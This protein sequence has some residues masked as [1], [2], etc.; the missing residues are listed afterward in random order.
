MPWRPL[1]LPQEEVSFCTMSSTEPQFDPAGN[2]KRTSVKR[3]NAESDILKYSVLLCV[4][5]YVITVFVHF[6]RY[7]EET[8]DDELMLEKL[9]ECKGVKVSECPFIEKDLSLLYPKI[10][11]GAEVHPK[12]Q[13]L[14]VKGRAEGSY[15]I[16]RDGVIVSVGPRHDLEF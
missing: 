2:A 16:V 14:E 15:L 12:D 3:D 6:L 9:W 5:L 4:I 11:R 13:V 8:F 10:I 7:D 1:N